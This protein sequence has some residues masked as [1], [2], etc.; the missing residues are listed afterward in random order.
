MTDRDSVG[1]GDAAGRIEA[2]L[3]N[4]AARADRE[5]SGR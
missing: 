4:L 2:L 1:D 5:G 3:A